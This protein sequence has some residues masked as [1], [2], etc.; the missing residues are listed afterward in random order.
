MSSAAEGPLEGYVLGVCVGRVRPLRARGRI[1][2]TGFVKD[3]AA[4][5]IPLGPLG[6][7]GDEHDF[8]D[9]GGPD[10]AL[11]VYSVDHYAFW[12]DEFGIDLPPVGAF[13]ENLTVTGLTE[14]EVCIGDTFRIGEAVAQVT[15]PRAP[16]YK[17]GLR[18]DRRELPVRMQEACRTGYMLRVV[19]G[20]LLRAGDGMRLISRPADA[21]TVAEAARVRNVD[22][23]DWEAVARVAALPELSAV[24]RRTLEA[25]LASREVE[26]DSL[27]LFGEGRG[28]P[29]A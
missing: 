10:Q 23:D 27:R 26:S 6:L 2:Q 21:V 25:R 3:P 19:S 5:P 12:E 28:E 24:M 29:E 8:P 7:E 20:G 11:L 18:V 15:S 17:I 13:G 22:R 16:C 9:H 1:H 4:G 14:D